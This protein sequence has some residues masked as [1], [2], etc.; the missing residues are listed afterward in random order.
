M[1]VTRTASTDV[2][3]AAIK[4]NEK[5]RTEPRRIIDLAMGVSLR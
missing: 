1:I 5:N 4:N 3:K 2:P